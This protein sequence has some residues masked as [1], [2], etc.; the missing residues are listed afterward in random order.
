MVKGMKIA[1][2]LYSVRRDVAADLR[3]TL[4]AVKA[5][6][7]DGVEFAGLGDH[8]PADIRA[9]V[10]EIGL[11]PISAHVPLAELTADPAGCIGK[12]KEIGCSF[13][14]IPWLVE[15]FRPGQP[16]Y[17]QF[18]KDVNLLAAEC[19]AQ[20]ITLLYHNHDFEFVKLD[21]EY[22][23][24]RMYADLPAL[25]TEIDT[26]WA[27]VGGEEPAAYVRKYTGRAPVVHLKDFYLPGKKPANL[28]QLIGVSLDQ[29][30]ED[31]G[32]FELRPLGAGQ[33]NLAALVDAA[34]EAGAGWVVVEQDEPSLG[35]TPLE[36]MKLS[37]DNLLAL[38]E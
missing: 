36:C 3:G 10:T 16:G 25:Q 30:P 15:E 33:Q 4:E 23:L 35:K 21:G 13:I 34:A 14:A 19:G 8:A 24:D 32:R 7:Y 26:C 1:A 5:M 20:G 28:Y 9:L 38:P 2:Q 17:E 6:G 11:E 27:N 31:G 29:Q 37:I 18:K 12:Y 22:L